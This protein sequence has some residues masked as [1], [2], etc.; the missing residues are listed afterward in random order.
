MTEPVKTSA[1]RQKV[2]GATTGSA[3][4]GALSV[5]VLWILDSGMQQLS[6]NAPTEVKDSFTVVFTTVFTFLGGYYT[7]PGSDEAVTMENGQMVA[8]KVIVPR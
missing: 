4:G 1:P 7:R 3:I 6:I 5:I 2:V 8:A